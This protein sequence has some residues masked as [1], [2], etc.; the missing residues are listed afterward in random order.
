MLL[1]SRVS[2]ERLEWEGGFG[3]PVRVLTIDAD[4]SHGGP[5][6][7]SMVSG[8]LSDPHRQRVTPIFE[9]FLWTRS[10]AASNAAR[11]S[12]E[13]PP[14]AIASGRYDIIIYY[15]G[16]FEQQKSEPLYRALVGAKTTLLIVYSV[17]RH[18]FASFFG[19]ATVYNGVPGV[20]L[21][22]DERIDDAIHSLFTELTHNDGLVAAAK[23]SIVDTSPLVAELFVTDRDPEPF[24]F[25]KW[26]YQFAD[27]VSAHH[28]KLESTIDT[29]TKIQEASRTHLMA[30]DAG[31]IDG[32][33]ERTRR[34]IHTLSNV[35]P[36]LNRLR[37]TPFWAHEIEGVVPIAH[38]IDAVSGM[39]SKEDD[40]IVTDAIKHFIEQA[41]QAPRVLNAGIADGESGAMQ[42][43]QTSL[44]PG[45]RY[46]LLVDVGPRWDKRESIV[47]GNAIFPVEALP[48]AD[49]GHVLDVVFVCDQ[50]E[51]QMV[52]ARLW[53]P[54]TGRSSPYHDDTGPAQ[55]GPA[56]LAFTVSR[57]TTEQAWLDGRLSI[58]YENTLLQSA[59]VSL[60]L[61]GAAPGARSRIEVD[62]AVSPDFQSLTK[63][64]ERTLLQDERQRPVERRVALNLTLNDTDKARIIAVGRDVPDGLFTYS[65]AAGK[66]MLNRARTELLNCFYIRTN[67]RVDEKHISVGKENAKN[68]RDFRKDLEKL[69]RLGNELYLGTLA[70]AFAAEDS[71][72][73]PDDAT[74]A[75]WARALRKSLQVGDVI[76]INRTPRSEYIVPW[77]LFYEI[78][79]IRSGA[80]DVCPSV[81]QWPIEASSIEQVQVCPNASVDHSRDILCPFAFWGLKYFVEQ[82]LGRGLGTRTDDEPSV[83]RFISLARTMD[84]SLD[85]QAIDEHISRLENI[86]GA[87]NPSEP[88]KDWK[89]V[90]A[91]LAS[92]QIVYLLCHGAYDENDKPY[93]SIGTPSG[94]DSKISPLQ[95][96]AYVDSRDPWPPP[97]PFVFINGCHTVDVRPGDF[98]NFIL[99]FGKLG[100]GAIVGTEIPMLLPVA[101]EMGQLILE[102]I[103]Q[104]KKLGEALYSARW[105]LARKRNLLGLAYTAY[106]LSQYQAVGAST[107]TSDRGA[108]VSAQAAFAV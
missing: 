18:A 80:F 8:L 65:E 31:A 77:A 54:N 75:N 29:L 108:A 13:D 7:A 19:A 99:G 101:I 84:P 11:V 3:I 1:I 66:D 50:I 107:T 58:Y 71:K 85:Q 17:D 27:Q 69:A 97:R 93:L 83:E 78:P 59:A 9:S 62:F 46:Q 10:N 6:I 72:T 73:P 38:T 105:A 96:T 92:P 34:G 24:Q 30:R 48:P 43:A 63:L 89:S 53:L 64:G 5:E 87:F 60:P 49:T 40:Q 28:K 44:T 100:A 106:G 23:K 4:G 102:R 33:V 103:I 47:I 67:G 56:G 98:L 41:S 82:T 94:A 36:R 22:A 81:D 35:A 95:L 70:N 2:S 39:L 88:A 68:D 25:T 45:T 15:G 32:F 51:P 104:G 61:Q 86:V 14:G 52:K 79:L 12:A 37:E 90:C 74:R 42:P 26:V 76:S 91:M 21:I 16:G 55:S 57:N 20:L